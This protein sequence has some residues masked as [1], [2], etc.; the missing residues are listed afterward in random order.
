MN[1][2]FKLECLCLYAFTLI[3]VVESVM[4]YDTQHNDTKH[5]EMQQN[6]K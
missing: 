6:N 2:H 1:F 3:S 5:N 4:R